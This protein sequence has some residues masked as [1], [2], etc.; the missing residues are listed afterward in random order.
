M[1]IRIFV[2]QMMVALTKSDGSVA[3]IGPGFDRRP[4]VYVVHFCGDALD[5]NSEHGIQLYI[6]TSGTTRP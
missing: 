1:L 3:A 2:Q 5:L 6:P 4:N